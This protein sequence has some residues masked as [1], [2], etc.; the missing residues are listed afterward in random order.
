MAFDRI[1]FFKI[2]MDIEKYLGYLRGNELATEYLET[3]NHSDPPDPE[4]RELYQQQGSASVTGRRRA[5]MPSGRSRRTSTTAG[6]R[7][8]CCGCRTTSPRRRRTGSPPRS[9][10]T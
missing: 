4:L 3:V 6:R 10:P 1:E 2:C 5:P 8:P 7:R 9:R